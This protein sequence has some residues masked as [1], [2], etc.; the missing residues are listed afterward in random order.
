MRGTDILQELQG[1]N[2]SRFK[3]IKWWRKENDFCDFQLLEDFKKNVE[4]SQEFAGY[5]LLTTE[6]MWDEL[7]TQAGDH[8]SLGKTHGRE[9]IR[10]DRPEKPSQVCPFTADSIMTIFDVETRGNVIDH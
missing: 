8:V 2:S 1:L 3:F 6:E 9:V 5:E 7:K 4:G 10:W